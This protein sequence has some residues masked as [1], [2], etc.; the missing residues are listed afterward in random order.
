MTYNQPL[1]RN[2]FVQTLKIGYFDIQTLCEGVVVGGQ[3]ALTL[4]YF[5]WVLK[6]DNFIR[7]SRK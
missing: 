3:D 2:F 7:I 1:P 5:I 4:T 6:W